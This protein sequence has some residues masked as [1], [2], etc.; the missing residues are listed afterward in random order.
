MIHSLHGKI[1]LI[2]IITAFLLTTLFAATVMINH[3]ETFLKQ[4]KRYRQSTLFILRHFRNPQNSIDDPNLQRFLESSNL[5]IVKSGKKAIL[6]HAQQVLKRKVFRSRFRLYHDKDSYYL[7]IKNRHIDLLLRDLTA[8]NFPWTMLLLYLLALTFLLLLYGW[9]IR[10]LKPLK[11]L[12]GEIE[13]FAAGDLHIHC[14]SDKKDEIAQVANEFDKAA[15]TIEKLLSSRQLFLRTI[16][17]ELKTPI[18]K[19]RILTAMLDQSREKEGFEHIF[20]RLELLLDEFA[21]I[22]QMLTSRYKVE[23]KPYLMRDI[24]DQA[25]ELLILDDPDDFIM[26]ASS[27]NLMIESDFS[28]LSLAVKNLL[29]NAIE[30]SKDKKAYVDFKE[31]SIMI[32]SKAEALAYP[33]EAYFKPFHH[34]SGSKSTGLG[35]GLYIVKSIVDLL[36]MQFNYTRRDE[37]NI[38][39]IS[40]V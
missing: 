35:L 19:G 5:A 23:I 14:Q 20:E 15:K 36:G 22:E 18:A 10:S 39:T 21:K 6:Q 32:S 3:K 16:M 33:L 4:Q 8:R 11:Q 40:N 7:R 31:E 27:P 26:I 30:Y 2:F 24:V 28:L 13:K 34:Q 12:Q 38:F 9:I 25:V 17:H 1:K 29:D 37:M